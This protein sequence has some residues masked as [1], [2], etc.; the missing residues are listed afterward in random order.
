LRHGPL[1]TAIAAGRSLREPSNLVPRFYR[2]SFAAQ[3]AKRQA[4]QNLWIQADSS[5]RYA[6]FSLSH[7]ADAAENGFAAALSS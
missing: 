3:G 5:A 7:G 1:A 2:E 4:L 6:A